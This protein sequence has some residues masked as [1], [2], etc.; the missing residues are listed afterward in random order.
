MAIDL[1]DFEHGRDYDGDYDADLAGLTQRL[2]RIQAAYIA[3]KRSA[4]I[5]FE[6]WDASG[7]GGRSSG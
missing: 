5:A 4:I 6:G 2:A 1:S 3:H 7:K